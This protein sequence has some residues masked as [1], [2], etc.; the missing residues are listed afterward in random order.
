MVGTWCDLGG[1]S[2]LKR[3]VAFL[4]QQELCSSWRQGNEHPV[5]SCTVNDPLKCFPSFHCAAGDPHTEA[6]AQDTL[7][8]PAVLKDVVLPEVSREIKSLLGLLHQLCYICTPGQVFHD[9]DSQEIKVRHPF[10]T[11]PLDVKWLDVHFL[12]PLIHNKL[13]GLGCVHSNSTCM[14]YSFQEHSCLSCAPE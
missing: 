5:I 2:L 12:F 1:R 9:V 10:L 6:V 11:V 13:L 8:T 3:S 14:I 4:R 7:R